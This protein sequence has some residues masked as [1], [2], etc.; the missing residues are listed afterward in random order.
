[1]SLID[2]GLLG[3]RRLRHSR[4]GA[5]GYSGT[6]TALAHGDETYEKIASLTYHVRGILLGIEYVH[7]SKRRQYPELTRTALPRAVSRNVSVEA[8][9]LH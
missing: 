6:A 1:M 7:G 2:G 9:A 8:L 3:R 4:G 5:R